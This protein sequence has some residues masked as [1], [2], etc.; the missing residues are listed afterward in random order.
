[1]I[2]QDPRGCHGFA[3]TNEVRFGQ[4]IWGD[5]VMEVK[6]GEVPESPALLEGQQGHV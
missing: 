6:L 5:E 2:E 4:A 1:M 3:Q